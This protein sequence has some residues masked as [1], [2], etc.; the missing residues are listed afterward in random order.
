M[1]K[2]P[3]RSYNGWLVVYPPLWKIWVRQLGWW[4]SQYIYIWKNNPFMFQTTNQIIIIFLL[5]VYS[6]FTTIHHDYKN[7][8]LAIIIPSLCQPGHQPD[9]IS[10]SGMS[11]T[12]GFTTSPSTAASK[13]HAL[14]A[15]SKKSVGLE[16]PVHGTCYVRMHVSRWSWFIHIF[17]G[18]KHKYEHK[19]IYT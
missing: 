16:P 14:S 17:F 13:R 2:N 15:W 18:G 3:L 4:H 10:I 19:N 12:L 11:S 9:G 8:Y 5:L 7:H 1:G 6:L